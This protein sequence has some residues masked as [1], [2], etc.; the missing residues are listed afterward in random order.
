MGE[1]KIKIQ[2]Q[3]RLEEFYHS[4]GF[5][6]ISQPYDHNGVPLTDMLLQMG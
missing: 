2:V 5:E 6:P 1:T 3:A 4:F